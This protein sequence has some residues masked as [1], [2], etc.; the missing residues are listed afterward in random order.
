MTPIGDYLLLSRGCVG[1]QRAVDA[2][3]LTHLGA[4]P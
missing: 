4:Q 2:L 3:E 1:D